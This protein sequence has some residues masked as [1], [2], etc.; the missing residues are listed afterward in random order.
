MR[1]SV[2]EIRRFGKG[3]NGGFPCQ[4]PPKPAA[5]LESARFVISRSAVQIRV[6]APSK[7]LKGNAFW[8]LSILG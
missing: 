2:A 3:R 7:P 4:A 1:G 6:S 5:G 8:G